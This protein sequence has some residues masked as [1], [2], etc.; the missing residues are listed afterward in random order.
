VLPATRITP[1]AYLDALEVL[2]APETDLPRVGAVLGSLTR[3][4][5]PC[6][7]RGALTLPRRVWLIGGTPSLPFRIP[8]IGSCVLAVDVVLHYNGVTALS[9]PAGF[10]VGFVNGARRAAWAKLSGRRWI[11]HGCNCPGRF[12]PYLGPEAGNSCR[13]PLQAA[14]TANSWEAAAVPAAP[15][16]APEDW[17]TTAT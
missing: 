17:R 12:T 2:Q 7:A 10:G 15:L 1:H 13:S 3:L 11:G 16:E 5:G 9:A 8:R 14:P 4:D 6:E